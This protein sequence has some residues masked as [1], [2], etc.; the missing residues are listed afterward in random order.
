QV[1]MNSSRYFGETDFSGDLVADYSYFDH[2][3]LVKGGRFDL[4]P[5]VTYDWNRSWGFVKPKAT[6]RYTTYD[7]ENTAANQSSSIDRTVPTFSLDSGLFFDRDTNWFGQQTTQTLEPR[8]FY[9]Y[10]PEENQDDIPRFDTGLYTFGPNSLFRENRFS[11]SDRIGDANQLTAAVTTRFLSDQT[12]QQYLAMTLGQIFYFEDREVGLSAT[13]PIETENTSPYIFTL[14]S[15]P[16][17]FWYLDGGLQW[18]DSD[19]EK[20]YLRTRYEDDQQRLF[21]ARYQF[22]DAANQEF[23]KFSAY[24]PVGYNTRLVGHSYYSWSEER[25]I[26]SL[27]GIEHGSSCCWRFRFLVRDY[28]TDTSQDNNL[29]F[30]MQL[31]LRGFANIGDDIDSVLE[32]SIEGFNR[33][34]Y[35]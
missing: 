22:D 3:S 7:L 9:V 16:A 11:G 34:N 18:D 32:D 26:E 5:S 12:G 23:T 17:P 8:L 24:W 27:A 13:S 10:T 19:M 30:Y 35:Q 15:K 33:R 28:Q 31:E 25:A 6:L 20:S 4:A 2:D 21:S 1:R 14:S 29:G